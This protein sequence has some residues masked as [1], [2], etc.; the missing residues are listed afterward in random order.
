[1]QLTENIIQ[2]DLAN[3]YKI[4]HSNTKEYTF[5]IDHGTFFQNCPHTQTQSKSQQVL[6]N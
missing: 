4:F 2:M 6:E 1:M 3:V 5:S